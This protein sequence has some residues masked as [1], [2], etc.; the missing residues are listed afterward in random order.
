M[1]QKQETLTTEEHNKIIDKTKELVKE[2]CRKEFLKRINVWWN[3]LDSID[4]SKRYK[5]TKDITTED[6][7]KLKEAV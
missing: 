4:D 1:K 6:L 5:N 7:K 2:E 3:S